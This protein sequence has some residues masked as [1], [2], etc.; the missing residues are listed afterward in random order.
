MCELQVFATI[1]LS[2]YRTVTIVQDT[3]DFWNG[4]ADIGHPLA[5]G[6]PRRQHLYLRT[7]HLTFTLEVTTA[8]ASA[9]FSI[10]DY[11][12]AARSEMAQP[13]HRLD[14]AT[15]GMSSARIVWCNC[16]AGQKIYEDAVREQVLA[17]ARARIEDR[18]SHARRCGDRPGG[19]PGP[20]GLPD[21]SV[22]PQASASRV[23]L[24]LHSLHALDA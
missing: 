21:R 3:A 12:Q 20:P 23:R 2:T 1:S 18:R 11:A 5:T 4:E 15:G 6:S 7:G 14:L 22:D 13:E 8:T 24:A 16:Q 9:V 17:E 19:D 10:Y